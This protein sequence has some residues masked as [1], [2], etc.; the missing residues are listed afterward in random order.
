MIIL[1]GLLFLIDKVDLFVD[2]LYELSINSFK[3]NKHVIFDE[4]SLASIINIIEKELPE[5]IL[6]IVNERLY[7][8]YYVKRFSNK[9]VGENSQLKCNYGHLSY[10]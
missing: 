4:E 9:R 8:T 3:K 5:N 7:I 10:G 2:T 6:S 1:I